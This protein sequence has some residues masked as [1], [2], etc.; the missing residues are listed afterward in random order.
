MSI[1]FQRVG[2]RRRDPSRGLRL[3]SQEPQARRGSTAH[4]LFR[5]VSDG[6]AP[7]R[8]LVPA[9]VKVTRPDGS[10][11]WEYGDST[12]IRGGV[13]L[14][15]LDLARNEP[16]GRWRLSVRELCSGKTA[17]AAVAVK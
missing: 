10:D 4:F 2:L 3:D 9:E 17:E 8:G 15:S 11:A 12:L 5:L 7:V 13:L 1:T 14:V 16:A 6:G